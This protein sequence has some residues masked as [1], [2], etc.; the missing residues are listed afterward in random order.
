MSDPIRVLCVFSTLDRGGAESMC[1][2]LYRHIDRTK[3]Q[4]DFVKH[5][6]KKGAFEDEIVSLGGKIYE[7]PRLK[8]FTI[9]KY[10]S[11]WKKHL[12]N[13]PEH[14]IIHGHFYSICPVYF[15]ISKKYGRLTVGHIHT[16]KPDR[17]TKALMARFISRVTDYPLA[18][19]CSAGEWVYGKRPFTVL[20]NA[21]DADSFRFNS[22]TAQSVRK[23]FDLG[24]N[25]VLGTVSR[26]SMVKNPYGTLEIFRLVHERHPESKL[27]WVGDGSMRPELQKKIEEYGIQR[28]V[29]LTGVRNDV[30]RLMQ[31]MDAFIFPSYYEGLGIAAVEAQA[32]GV[33]TF[34]SNTIPHEVSVTE[35][36]YFL[37]LNDY[38]IWAKSIDEFP[39]NEIH[40]DMTDTIKKAGYDIHDTAKWLEEFYCSICN[41]N[42]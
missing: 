31:G 30:S 39:A 18:C 24:D 28:D 10:N 17:L 19:S 26:F 33:P 15:R 9:G 29:I 1:M 41:V 21:I 40:P 5:T 34:C 27:L 11:W 4:F 2:N 3:V 36:C 32:A 22:N 38:E 42:E 25:L 35:L 14:Q 37:P 13:H 16:T 8:L 7:A 20:N 6:S 12:L 23:E